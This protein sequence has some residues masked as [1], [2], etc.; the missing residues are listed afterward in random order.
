MCWPGY[1]G[2]VL[3]SSSER[4]CCVHITYYS[5]RCTCIKKKTMASILLAIYCSMFQAANVANFVVENVVASEKKWN[6]RRYISISVFQCLHKKVFVFYI[7]YYFF[8]GW[9]ECNFHPWTFAE[10]FWRWKNFLSVCVWVQ[11]FRVWSRFEWRRTICVETRF[12]KWN[13]RTRRHMWTEVVERQSLRWT[14]PRRSPLIV[15]EL[16]YL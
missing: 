2:I 13:K 12:K 15:E 16:R 5:H 14:G 4:H 11:S 6:V 1:V 8:R 10:L 3:S 7:N 9:H